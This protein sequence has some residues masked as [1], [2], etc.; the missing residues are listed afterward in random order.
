MQTHYKTISELTHVPSIGNKIL[1]DI[2]D[3]VTVE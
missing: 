3:L 2:E 1:G